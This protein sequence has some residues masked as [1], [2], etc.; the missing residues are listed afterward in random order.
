MR[1]RMKFK[2]KFTFSTRNQENM[3]QLNQYLAGVKLSNLDLKF[4]GFLAKVKEYDKNENLV[5]TY[6]WYGFDEAELIC[7]RKAG[8]ETY[9]YQ[10]ETVVLQHD[11]R[12]DS[13]TFHDVWMR[14]HP[15]YYMRQLIQVAYEESNAIAFVIVYCTR[16]QNVLPF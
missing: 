9:T 3:D 7:E 8:V 1:F 12:M 4:K 6:L 5:R 11:K 14:E 13:S 10:V 2:K 16:F 15:G